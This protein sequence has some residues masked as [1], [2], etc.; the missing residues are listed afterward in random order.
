MTKMSRLAVAARRRMRGEEGAEQ[1]F[2]LIE[3]LV[4]L[5]IIGILLAIAIPTF[6]SVTK[7][8][9]DTAAQ[10]NLQTALTGS[11]TYYTENNQTY[12]G[13]C[14]LAH[15]VGSTASSLADVDTGLSLISKTGSSGPHAVSVN[16]NAA[17]TE[18]TLAALANGTNNCWAVVDSTASGNTVN[19]V[20][21]FVGTYYFKFTNSSASACAAS[22]IAVGSAQGANA[23]VNGFGGI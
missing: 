6:L 22:T 13:L 8:A 3:L 10:S 18:V 16:T 21:N 4:V 19:G 23:S 9:N 5:L 17:G 14:P 2:T 1:G 11:K 20:A 7:S 12:T 15:C